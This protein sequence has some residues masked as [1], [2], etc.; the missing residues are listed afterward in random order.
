MADEG[1]QFIADEIGAAD[2]LAI[3]DREEPIPAGSGPGS[4][5]RFIW[6][7]HP[8]PSVEVPPAIR[9]RLA[10][11]DPFPFVVAIIPAY[12]EQDSI[13][14][15]IASL[16]SQTR[17]PD[18]IIVVTNNCT[19][20]T[21]YIA[22]ATGVTVVES[23]SPDGKAG[24]LNDLFDLIMPMLADDDPVLVMDADT[25]LTERFIESTVTALRG[26]SNKLIAGVGG[27]FL[28]D[29]APW[30]LVR[31][32]QTNEYVRYQRRLS[33]R[34][35]RALVLTGTGTVFKAG[36]MRE[37]RQARRDGRMPDLAYAGGVYDISAL[38]EDNELT[39]CA[40]ELGYRVISPKDCTVKTAMMPTLASLY[41]QRLRWQRGALEN[42]IAHGLN[43]NTAPYAIRQVLTYLGVLFVPFYLWTLAI[44]LIVQSSLN[45]FQPLW[46][47]VAVMYVAEQTFSVRKGGW[48]AVLVS[49]AVLPEI[50]FNL[51]LN[52]VYVISAYGALFATD[53]QWG[54][55]RHLDPVKFDKRGKPLLNPEPP[56]G[57]ALHGTHPE[58]WN[59]RGRVTGVGLAVLGILIAVAFGALPLIN[60][61]A[62][63][64]VVAVYVLAGSLATVGRL[65]PVR[66]S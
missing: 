26:P 2:P 39:I 3:V 34:R 19:D 25:V 64:L 15:S 16:R 62:A 38:T 9:H 43:R 20:D 29:D 65:V 35:G 59:R 30:N 66:T 12:N 55:M 11:G 13:S 60:L 50:F 17:P 24:A 49:L 45:F 63:W 21:E 41:R 47:G 40:K 32:L 46:V 56:A 14:G 5:L 53:E 57:S 52:V 48:R 8:E 22:F 6:E 28:A 18:Q 36:F 33:R 42:L 4:I 51:F 61:P 23:E 37:A 54:R 27:I 1:W 44:A 7:G 31:Q 58:R 10:N